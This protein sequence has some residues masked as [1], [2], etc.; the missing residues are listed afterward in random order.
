MRVVVLGAPCLSPALRRQ[1]AEV[2]DVRGGGDVSIAHP[3][4]AAW[5]L[6]RL[7]ERGFAPD[8]LIHADDGNMPRLLDPER[9]PT[10][11]V[12][13]SIDTY[14]NPWHVGYA[15]G[16]DR[17]LV[18]QKDFLPLFD[19]IRAGEATWFPLFADAV[20]DDVAGTAER[21]IPVAFVGTLGHP[22]NPARAPFMGAFRKLCPLAL[23]S[24]DYRPVFAR[25][26]IVLNQTAFSELNYR[27]FQAAAC[28]A[29][30]LMERCGNGLEEI[31]T[32]GETILPPYVRNDAAH[33]AGIARA[34][35]ADADRTAEIAAAGRDLV[36]REHSDDA[37]ARALLA[38]LGE[39]IR[40]GAQE[41][42]RADE[43]RR[44]FMVRSCYGGIAAELDRPD[45]AAHRE[46]FLDWAKR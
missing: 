44:K 14:C 11:S 5:L 46:F 43:G 40:D 23:L 17:I 15:A 7:A 2:A 36:L 37:R 10:P 45:L 41:A 6:E 25:S 20:R 32:P 8:A 34:A 30:L 28:G 4:V 24:G 39:M 12:F 13:F 38:L 19:G 9:W 29:A 3:F 33:A 21:D 35:M 22:N 18:A 26:R 1:G 42:R 27:C 16:F 31:F